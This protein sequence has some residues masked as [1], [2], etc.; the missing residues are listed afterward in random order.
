[1][2]AWFARF[3]LGGSKPPQWVSA[4]SRR[5]TSSRRRGGIA[6]RFPRVRVLDN[7]APDQS[8]VHRRLQRLFQERGVKPDDLAA[9]DNFRLSRDVIPTSFSR[10]LIFSAKRA[11]DQAHVIQV[12][13]APSTSVLF[14][15]DSGVETERALLATV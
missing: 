10:L 7:P 6:A 14:M 11:D 5:F 15:S 4:Y 12:S 13:I 1:M 8:S 9:G 3:A 2:N